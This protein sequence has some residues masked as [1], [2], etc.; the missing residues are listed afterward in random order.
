LVAL[1]ALVMSAAVASAPSS[2]STQTAG[3]AEPT[4]RVLSPQLAGLPRWE[5]GI[6]AVG[7]YAPDYRGADQ[8]RARGFPVPYLIYRGDWLRA[9]REGL[10]AEFL[11]D[12][13]VQ[14]NFSAGLGLPVE[15]DSN[16]AR[17]GMPEIDWVVELGPAMNINLSRWDDGRAEL[18]LRLPVR[19]ALALDSGVEYVGAVFAPN[20]RATFRNI[21][22]AGGAQL[23]VSTGPLFATG[24]YHRFYYGVEPQF[25]T[26]TR[27]AYR[28]EA[29]YSGWDLSTSIVRF[30]GNWRLFGFAGADFIYGAAFEDS[31]LIRKRSNWSVGGGFAYVFFRSDERVTSRE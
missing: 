20:L 9:D 22:W 27:P 30:I 2:E 26:A 15:S 16:E 17:Q 5:A 29:G 7:L 4:P 19:A 11:K 1:A 28:P 3:S 31:P 21:D 14:F 18:D 8:M 24:D 10:R 23:R 13:D 25:A 12:E 6:G